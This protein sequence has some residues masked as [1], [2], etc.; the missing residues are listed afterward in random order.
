MVKDW[1]ELTTEEI[2]NK[3]KEF[4]NAICITHCRDNKK[5]Y[6]SLVKKWEERLKIK[7]NE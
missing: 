4:Q 1:R 5:I 7:L 2:K 3:I 6:S